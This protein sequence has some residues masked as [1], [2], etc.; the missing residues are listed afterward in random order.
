MQR[1]VIISHDCTDFSTDI[2]GVEV[3]FEK[4]LKLYEKTLYITDSTSVADRLLRLQ[5]PW[6]WCGGFYSDA[7]Y[8]VEELQDVDDWYLLQAY[9]HMSNEPWCVYEDSD[10]IIREMTE[11]DLPDMYKMYDKPGVKEY[12]EPLYGYDDELEFTK[13]YINSMY[14]FYG[15]GLWLCF[16][17]RTGNLVGRAGFS[18][19]E[20]DGEE[21][22]ELGY[23][24]DADYQGRGIAYRLCRRLLE[25]GSKY[26]GFKEIFVCCDSKNTRS[27]AL[28][29]KL[30]FSYYGTCHTQ[31]L[32]RLIPG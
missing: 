5:V 9:A 4:E 7:L 26:W 30:G 2:P 19:R 1:I 18:H 22:V 31:V 12:V 10:Y 8:C 17:K 16:E 3:I 13:S 29:A 15:Y 28:A 21:K 27:I 11:N 25:L 23:I 32:Y 24:I 6:I 20:I 14:G